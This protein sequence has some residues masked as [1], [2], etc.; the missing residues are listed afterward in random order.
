MAAHVG[1]FTQARSSAATA[2]ATTSRV[3]AEILVEGRSIAPRAEVFEC[4]LRML[5]TRRTVTSSRLPG[6]AG[7]A[8]GSRSTARLGSERNPSITRDTE[9]TAAVLNRWYDAARISKC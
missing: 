7:G 4:W 6:R 1:G 3:P 8:R 9:G 5:P 2:R